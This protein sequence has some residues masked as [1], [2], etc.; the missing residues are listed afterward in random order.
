MVTITVEGVQKQYPTGTTYEKIA[1]EYQEKY[2]GLIALVSVNGKIRELFKKADKDCHVGFFTLRDD[3]G[4]K[5]YVR[6]ATM[7]MLKAVADVM[8]AEN[9]QRCRVEYTI[10]HGYYIRTFDGFRV[11]PEQVEQ[12]KERMQQL[13]AEKM[14]IKKRAYPLAEAMELFKDKG[15]KDKEKLFRY[16]RSSYVNI[17]ELDGYFDYYYGY[18]LP[19]AGYMPYFDLIPYD[20]GMMLLLPRKSRPT[21]IEPFVPREKLFRTLK[22]SEEWGNKVGIETVGDL[23]EQIC[24]G[25]LSEMVLVQEA[26]QERKIGEIAKDIVKRGGVKFI[27]IAGPSSSGKTSFSHRLSIQLRTLGLVP[28]PIALDDYF[29][30]RDQTPKDENGDYNFE[31]LEAIDIE[32]FNK[33]MTDLLAGKTVELP[34]FNFKTGLREYREMSGRWDRRMYW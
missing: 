7:V 6:T 9:A 25:N 24:K 13:V 1:S 30:N 5:T 23:N 14:P 22:A 33:D 31:C 10:G 20:E 2:D 26:E 11:T 27:M 19:N 34:S 8:G 4:H 28:H 17:Y 32:Q 16:R 18:M 12:I 3:V 21:E 29:V 15:M